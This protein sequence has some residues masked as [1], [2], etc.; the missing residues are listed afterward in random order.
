MNARQKPTLA[1]AKYPSLRAVFG[2]K[3]QNKG[4]TAKTQVQKNTIDKL[5]GVAMSKK[6]SVAKIDERA[7]KENSKLRAIVTVADGE[8]MGGGVR[9]RSVRKSTERSFVATQQPKL[10]NRE[11][12]AA[13]R[14][15]QKPSPKIK[16][17]ISQ[18]IMPKN[19]ITKQLISN[20]GGLPTPKNMPSAKVTYRKT[21]NGPSSQNINTANVNNNVTKQKNEIRQTSKNS[22][23]RNNKS[24]NNTSAIVYD[25]DQ[26]SMT[27][28]K[29]QQAKVKVA[30][31][32]VSQKQPVLSI[33]NRIAAQPRVPS[34]PRYIESFDCEREVPESRSL[35][36]DEAMLNNRYN[37]VT[38]VCAD[39][40][41]SDDEILLESD[42]HDASAIEN[43]EHAVFDNTYDIDAINYLI[44]QEE[45]YKTK[46]DYL[47]RHQRNVLWTMRAILL[48]WI[49]EVC[50]DYLFKRETFHYA[51]NYVDRYLSSV[52][53][54]D[55]RELQ[56]VGLS[57][58]F[59]AAKMEEVFTPKIDNILTAANNSYSQVQLRTMETHLYSVN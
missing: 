23:K 59:L 27:L 25:K 37:L 19:I 38:E 7:F 26:S 33:I 11:E 20:V 48:D 58:L 40:T 8:T 15:L 44:S 49:Q 45:Q 34:R 3:L 55:L 12:K 36:C 21:A 14:L 2:K 52:F 13:V 46:P 35:A 22:V 54:I 32:D 1:C 42:E 30:P 10:G 5:G 24:A 53:H 18:G 29:S 9:L 28:L 56:L 41:H 43:F 16:K 4:E 17:L 39:D 47:D 6:P 31:Q 50:S 57:A 51:I